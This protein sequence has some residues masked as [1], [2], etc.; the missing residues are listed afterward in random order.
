MEWY[1][2]SIACLNVSKELI[3]K[4]KELSKDSNSLDANLPY[5]KVHIKNILENC[6]SPLDYI[7]LHLKKTFNPKSKGLAYFPILY[8][9]N[10]Y[11]KE[12]GYK[13]LVKIFGKEKNCFTPEY[14]LIE[15]ASLNN[16]SSIWISHLNQLVNKNKH[17][18]LTK[19]KTYT[20]FH[21][22][23]G[24][25]ESMGIYLENSTLGSIENLDSSTLNFNEVEELFFENIGFSV[26][27]TLTEIY[28]SVEM[29]V[30]SLYQIEKNKEKH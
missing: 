30:E 5:I 7:A 23:N 3:E 25:V 16:M 8:R 19:R 6:R 20:Q 22:E 1:S 21:I 12:E 13:R 26:N 2:D 28:N 15:D 14:K 24:Y 18:N 17:N 9:N 10:E 4:I 11:P 29:I 27:V